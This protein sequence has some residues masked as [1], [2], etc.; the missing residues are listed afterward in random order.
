MVDTT[1]NRR[2]SVTV[3]GGP[4]TVIEIGGIRFL[5]D[6][7]F[8][9][10]R[11]YEMPGGSSL[12]KTQPAPYGPDTVRPLDV[13]L[14][15]H[16]EHPDNLDEAGRGL[17]ADVPLVLTTESGADRL[18]GDTRGLA[19]W[20]TVDVPLPDGGSITVTAVPARH[21]PEGCE[22][23]T[24]DVIGFVLSGDGL[25]TVYVSGDNASL[26]LVRDIAGRVGTVDTAVIFA[27]AVR[28]PELFDGA[29]LTLDSAGAAQAAVEL[30]APHVVVAHTDSWAHFTESWDDVVAAFSAAGIVDRLQQR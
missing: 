24:G 18:G 26:D 16:D 19:P 10:P 4:T 28:N 12:T 22:P 7:T 5:T 9:E 3:V 8:D 11:D 1:T 20:A 15:S 25:P 30:G 14:L 27:G 17:L 6:P 21:G 29:L 23:V 2:A 13:V